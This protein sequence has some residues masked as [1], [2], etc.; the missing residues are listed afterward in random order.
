MATERLRRNRSAATRYSLSIAWYVLLAGISTAIF[1]GPP[2]VP[3]LPT[4]EN[5][6]SAVRVREDLLLLMGPGNAIHEAGGEANGSV[7]ARLIQRLRELELE[8]IELP[9]TVDD[10]RMVNVLA[11]RPGTP[12]YRPIVLASHYD[13]CPMGPGAGDALGCVAAILESVRC[14][15]S[16]G[17]GK[18]FW[19]L[20]TDGEELGLLGAQDFVTT[21]PMQRAKLPFVIN[22][23]ARGT[24]GA[25]PMFESHRENFAT[26][27]KFAGEIA[28]PRFTTSLM[29]DVYA[30]LPNKTDFTVFKE[31]NWM[32]LNFALIGGAHRY[33]TLEDTPENVSNRSLQHFGEQANQL[34]NA[35]LRLTDDEWRVLESEG[36]S[37][38]FDLLGTWVV[39]YSSL[40]NPWLSVACWGVYALVVLRFS[41]LV[42]LRMKYIASLFTATL[43]IVL[44]GGLIGRLIGWLASLSMDG[45]KYIQNG[46][47]ASIGY[48]L[49]AVFLLTTIGAWA[50]QRRNLYHARLAILFLYSLLGTFASV[51]LPGGAYL[52]QWPVL[53]WG[54]LLLLAPRER[55][56]DYVAFGLFAVIFSPM[57]ALFPVALG[58]RGG[59][60][61]TLVSALLLAPLT[62][63]YSEFPVRI[64][65]P[66]ETV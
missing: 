38:H 52:F 42:T 25:T 32:G 64:E 5:R 33:H 6:V 48:S 66:P 49:L 13:S 17:A 1:Q 58:I 3:N 55:F 47:V 30:L 10:R 41:R 39:V 22:F 61:L 4:N 35:L 46:D 56:A 57:L 62:S 34:M 53:L 2:P 14:I 28:W 31:A 43:A 36:T 20:I 11:R 29:S 40:I 63:L 12:T 18:E 51:A 27:A 45:R 19:V 26:M 24:S 50:F 54:G 37:V 44:L 23:D 8:V 7:R 15:Q 9:F 59:M 21:N 16:M 60:I 65:N